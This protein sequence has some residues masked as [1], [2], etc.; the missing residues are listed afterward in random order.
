MQGDSGQ[1]LKSPPKS[2]LLLLLSQFYSWEHAARLINDHPP[3]SGPTEK[4]LCS[5]VH[6]RGCTLPDCISCH[7][8]R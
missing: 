2:P 7:F 8:C 5:E 6:P 4:T 1:C 3:Y